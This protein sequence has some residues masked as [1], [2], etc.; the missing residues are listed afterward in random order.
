MKRT[1]INGSMHLNSIF[2]KEKK[3]AEV[4]MRKAY[5]NIGKK[6]IHFLK[7]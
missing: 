2:A 4:V 3:M 7:T 1:T 6:I 5:E